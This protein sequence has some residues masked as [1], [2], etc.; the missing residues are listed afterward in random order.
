MKFMGLL[1]S[2]NKDNPY[3]I[4]YNESIAVGSYISAEIWKM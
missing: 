1:L 3:G 2:K 4:I